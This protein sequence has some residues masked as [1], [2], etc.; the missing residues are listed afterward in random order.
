[1][2]QNL[3][4]PPATPRTAR[5]RGMGFVR[6][7]ARER[8]VLRQLVG[9][10]CGAVVLWDHQLRVAWASPAAV[11]ALGGQACGAA[12]ARAAAAAARELVR[13]PLAPAAVSVVAP[14]GRVRAGRAGELEVQFSCVRAPDAPPWLIAELRAPRDGAAQ[15]ATMTPAELRV[16]H[17]LVRGLSNRELASALFVSRETAKTHVARILAKLGVGSRAKAAALARDAGLDGPRAAAPPR[18]RPSKN[19]PI[20]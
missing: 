14:P 5:A 3:A 13:V 10:R 2:L 6:A 20:G 11:S 1:M 17:L 8:E 12:L 9:A 19:P 16:L 4:M 15:L 18:P 7:M